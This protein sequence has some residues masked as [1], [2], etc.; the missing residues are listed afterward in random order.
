MGNI[1][2]RTSAAE[3][4]EIAVVQELTGERTASSAIKKIIGGYE[5]QQQELQRLRQ[6]LI[7][8]KAKNDRYRQ[9]IFGLQAA[10]TALFGL[11]E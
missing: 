7:Q 3:D 8:A 4:A 10:Q 9:A 2:L 11:A 6:E 5:Q 1:T